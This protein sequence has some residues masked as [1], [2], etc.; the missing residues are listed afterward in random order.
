M[1]GVVDSWE[2]LCPKKKGKR[3]KKE[4]KEKPVI[5]QASAQRQ[6]KKPLQAS[7]A[8]AEAPLHEDRE[9]PLIPQAE[10]EVEPDAGASEARLPARD[11]EPPPSVVELLDHFDVLQD[12]AG[13][14]IWEV[15]EEPCIE[16]AQLPKATD[17]TVQ[18][19]WEDMCDSD[20]GSTADEPGGRLES[21]PSTTQSSPAYGHIPEPKACIAP[22]W[23]LST[24]SRRRQQLHK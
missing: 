5:H 13:H 23:L 11:W 18:E 22:P 24:S 16:A 19:S 6:R 10:P 8:E 15:I 20:A 4:K 1:I 9:A 7:E 3:P 21:L 2:E 12:G 17:W 14:V